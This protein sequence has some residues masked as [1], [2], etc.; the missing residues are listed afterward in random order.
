M[1]SLED[2]IV[3]NA[4]LDKPMT[5]YTSEQRRLSISSWLEARCYRRL[6]RHPLHTAVVGSLSFSGFSEMALNVAIGEH[7]M[8]VSA[9]PPI[10]TAGLE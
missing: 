4:R 6:P 8:G 7:R 3:S 9:G 10:G 5:Y 2:S 1:G